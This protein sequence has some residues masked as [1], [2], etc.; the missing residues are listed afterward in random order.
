VGRY[1]LDSNGSGLGPV[2]GSCEYG[3]H[4]YGSKNVLDSDRLLG[5]KEWLCFT[6]LGVGGQWHLTQGTSNPYPLWV[7]HQRHYP[8]NF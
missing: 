5:F 6:E 4:L 7:K 2:T 8:S 3:N 1:G